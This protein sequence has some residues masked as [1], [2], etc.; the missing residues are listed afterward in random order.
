MCETK[1]DPLNGSSSLS[2]LYPEENSLAISGVRCYFLLSHDLKMMPYSKNPSRTLHD[3]QCS[4]DLLIFDLDGT[5]IDSKDDIAYCF[6]QTLRDFGREPMPL[7]ALLPYIGVGVRALF[8]KLFESEN[9]EILQEVL[10]VFY[11]YYLQNLTQRTTLYPG[12]MD[13]IDYYASK[14]KVILT[15]KLQHLADRVVDD[16]NLRTHFLGVYGREAFSTH[17]PSPEPILKICNIHAIE[18]QRSVMI[19]DT[20]IDIQAGRSANALTAGVLYGYGECSE[21]KDGGAHYLLREIGDLKQIF[22]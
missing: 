9:H 14:K 17:K 13:V 12:V 22:I 3:G 2:F 7:G 16:F 20:S 8:Y 19:G 5:L 18:P 4:V 10:S 1:Y 6:N 11:D 21:L 15:N